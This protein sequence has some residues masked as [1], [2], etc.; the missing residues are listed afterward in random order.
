M[1]RVE[2]QLAEQRASNQSGL[3][4]FE[5]FRGHREHQTRLI[6]AS[7]R[8]ASDRLCVLGAGNAYDLELEDLLARFAEVHLV[9][10][11]AQALSRA[12]ARVSEAAG[13]RLFT[14]APVDLSGMFEHL[15]RWARLQ[16][17]PDELMK[18]PA[19]GA[20]R[21][22]AALPGPFD[23]VA[24]TCLLTQLQLSLLRVVGDRHQLFVALREFLT[25]TH[26]RT[27][28]ALTKPGGEA[29]LVTDL[30]EAAAFP[31]GSGSE[32]DL[33]ALMKQL[34]AAGHVIHSSH[35]ESIRLTLSDD[36]VLSRAF[37]PS[38]VSEPWLWHNGPQLRFL[39]YAFT[40]P[41]R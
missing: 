24:S 10:V 37:G 17:T 32:P 38:E 2:Q 25:L 12:R 13:A 35:P 15:E 1:S 20:K 18:A 22:A 3:P 33:P 28:A 4:H 34:V 31:P 40:L 5:A 39:V 7:Q 11:D 21:I 8:Q 27:L 14:H 23:V 36:P 29:L 30:C 19:A 16:I 9:D 41:R 6:S 26:L